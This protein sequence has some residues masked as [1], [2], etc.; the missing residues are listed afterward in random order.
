MWLALVCASSFMLGRAGNVL[1]VSASGHVEIE[2]GGDDCCKDA[3]AP[4][5]ALSIAD[6]CDCTDTPLLQTAA[7]SGVGTE[8]L[9]SGWT[10]R[11]DA[12]VAPGTIAAPPSAS[13]LARTP[14]GPPSFSVTV[15]SLR[16]VILLA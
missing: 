4:V 7:R 11:S 16:T 9:V 10:P 5:H 14:V 6:R 12:F 3:H 2:N 8:R 15:A 1:C 13:P